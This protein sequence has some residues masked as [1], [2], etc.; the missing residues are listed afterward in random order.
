MTTV[1][2]CKTETTLLTMWVMCWSFVL[3]HVFQNMQIYWDIFSINVLNCQ[4]NYQF[5][6]GVK[7]RYGTDSPLSSMLFYKYIY[8]FFVK[9]LGHL[10][11]YHLFI[12]STS[13]VSKKPPSGDIHCIQCEHTVKYWG[14]LRHNANLPAWVTAYYSSGQY[15]S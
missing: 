12:T 1:K 13:S 7:L 11:L 6:Q 4:I 5:P 2:V 3:W 9:Y 8:I 15:N 14:M 10:V